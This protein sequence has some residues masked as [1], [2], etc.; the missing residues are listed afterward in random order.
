M[1][2][3]AAETH[4]LT[5]IMEAP[6]NERPFPYSLVENVF[7][8]DYYA[9]I[10]KHLPPLECYDNLGETGKVKK[11]A[12]K[13]RYITDIPILRTRAT[14]PQDLQFWTELG[15][16]MTAQPF[17]VQMLK[18][19]EAHCLQRFAGKGGFTFTTD[20]RLVRDFT[21]YA[22]GPHTDTPSKVLSLLFY[23]PQ[24]ERYAH[25]GTSIYEPP[26]GF[27][28]KGGPHYGFDGFKK[29]YT[30]PFTPNTLFLFFK[31]PTSFH[32]VEPIADVDVERNVL[33]YNI[34]VNPVPE[35]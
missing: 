27:T 29:K 32:G 14:P 35:L 3:S 18:K 16:W 19:F 7:P 13:E 12:Y 2:S 31:T 20:F 25:L 28:C 26:P 23:L 11:G 34:Y 1:L 8:E 4:I 22:I 17:L 21:H 5:H 33:L 10:L 15:D 6:L 9:E 24:D 30:A